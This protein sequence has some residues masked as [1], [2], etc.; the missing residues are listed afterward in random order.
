[1]PKGVGRSKLSAEHV[2]NY[3]EAFKAIDA[4]EQGTISKEELSGIM[5]G[6]DVSDDAIDAALA[7]FDTDRDGSMDVEEYLDFVY[8]SMLEQ[9]RMFMKAADTSG[10]GKLNK[11]E[12]AAVFEQMGMGDGSE[13]L[14]QA[15]DDGS[16]SLSIDEIVDYLLEV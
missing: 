16:G 15:D 4:D 6:K 8:V 3:L 12:L 13:A 10:D 11:D 14:S 9:A 7:K 2:E 1:M 5:G